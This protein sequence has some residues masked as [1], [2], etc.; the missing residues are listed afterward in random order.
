MKIKNSFKHGS[1]MTS[2]LLVALIFSQCQ[3]DVNTIPNIEEEAARKKNNGTTTITSGEQVKLDL[4]KAS[5]E[6]GYAYYID[7]NIPI[8]GDSNTQ[9]T[10]SSLKVFEN[11]KELGPAHASHK[12]IRSTGNGRF[13]HWGNSLYFSASD[14]TNPL[15]NG[16][17]YTISYAGSTGDAGTGTGTT[18]PPT[19]ADG[20]VK[21]D[22]TKAY[23]ESGNSYYIG[24]NVPIAGD[25]GAQ[26]TA[27]SLKIFENGKELGPAHSLHKDIRDLGQGRFSHW[28]NELYFSSS[29]N[30][31][32]LTNGRV[33]TISYTGS[34]SGIITPEP[35]VTTQPPTNSSTD[36]PIGF[37]S[38]NGKTTGGQGGRTVTVSTLA[39][40][41]KAVGSSETLIVQLAGNIKGTGMITVKS[42]K[43]ILGLSGSSL[44]GT[45][46]ALYGVSN[47]IIR[48][49]KISNVVG[50]DGITIKEASHHIWVDHNELWHDRNHGWDYYDELLEVTDRSDFVTI[51][52]NKFHDSNIALLIGSG[53][54]QTTDIGHLR[55]TLHNNYFYNNSERQP[56]TRFGFIHCFNN[57]L[58]NGSGYGIGVTM[59]ATVR[60][61]NNYFEG[62]KYPIY[63]NY[64]AKPGV[65][66]GAS[67]NIYQNSGANVISTKESFWVP[68]YEYKSVLIPAADV[69]SVVKNGAGPKY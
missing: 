10:V 43:T 14:N 54:Q 20:Q 40:F 21:L 63:T 18:P 60:T 1:V 69:P 9:P 58:Y 64:N 7:L 12:D 62:Q 11:G 49:M 23:K 45:G 55:V 44:D 52:W 50:G 33:Y 37:A 53:D 38:V 19:V 34:G 31:D 51:S 28:G 17:T 26:P 67:T 2:F 16:R 66:S 56:S 39:E 27:S 29:D 3:K 61:D 42:N 24:L 48:N 68:D 30:S 65:V 5:K 35:P 46:L 15:T 47:I 22:L 8:T 13:S 36:A 57:Y 41:S 6:S 25:S 32:P 59:D 4:T